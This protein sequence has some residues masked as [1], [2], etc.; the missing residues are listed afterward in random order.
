LFAGK[1]NKIC[2]KK[3]CGLS[4]QFVVSRKNFASC[5]GVLRIVKSNDFKAG[6]QVARSTKIR[7]AY[8]IFDR[9]ACKTII[10]F[11]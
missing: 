3:W 8:K 9:E 7:S 6:G 2:R 11:S 1:I 10:D 5:T 4:G